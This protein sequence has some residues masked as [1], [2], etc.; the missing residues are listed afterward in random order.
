MDREMVADA[1]LDEGA[2]DN[3]YHS[4]DDEIIAAV[5]ES[6]R[7]KRHQPNVIGN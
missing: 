1:A 3:S 5:S 7:S 6:G 4:E 2:S